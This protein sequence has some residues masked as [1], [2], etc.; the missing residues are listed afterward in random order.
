M[1]L[2]NAPTLETERLV[3]RGPQVADFEPLAAFYDSEHCVGFGGRLKRD[4]A[5]R[6]FATNVGH[7][8]IHGYGYFSIVEKASGAVAGL[9]GIWNPEGWPEPELGYALF[10]AFE[11]RG[12]AREG[13]E[14]ARQWAFED[15]GFKTLS[16]HIVPGNARSIALAERMG[17]TFEK[18]YHNPHMGE[19][20]IYRY[21]TPEYAR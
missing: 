10:E 1:T 3:L 11:G 21:P 6:W 12:I 5:W 17:G 15:L 2:T 19:D 13:A 8:H 20:H 18:A 9:T 14:R 7:W 16:S 4:E